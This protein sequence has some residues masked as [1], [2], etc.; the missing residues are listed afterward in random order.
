MGGK[1]K[2]F[3]SIA[4][5]SAYLQLEQAGHGG[6]ARTWIV[7]QGQ[8]GSRKAAFPVKQESGS[9]VCSHRAWPSCSGQEGE[10]NKGLAT[11]G[12]RLVP[13]FVA[14]SGPIA[15]GEGVMVWLISLY[16]AS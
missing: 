13:F 1:S 9:L 6:F 12:T 11:R 8:A 16:H 14:P 4:R 5:W 7:G 3:R 2:D 10:R 15:L